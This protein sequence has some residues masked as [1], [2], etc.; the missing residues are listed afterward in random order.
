MSMVNHTL[1]AVKITKNIFELRK[2]NRDIEEVSKIM[3]TLQQKREALEAS[4]GDCI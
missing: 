4:F 1:R 2:I 3:D